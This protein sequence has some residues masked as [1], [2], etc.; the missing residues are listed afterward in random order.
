[1]VVSGNNRFPPP[2]SIT[3]TDPNVRPNSVIIPWYSEVSNGNAIAIASQGNGSFVA[4][5]S[6]NKTF[7]YAVFN[8]N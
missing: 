8:N 2:G 7:R 4:S 5:G 6:P 3:I 1:M